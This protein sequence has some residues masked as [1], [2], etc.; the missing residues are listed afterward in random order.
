MSSFAYLKH[1][2]VD[3]LKIDG[4]FVKDITTDTVDAAMVDA[5]N[6]IGHVMGLKTIAEFAE[7]QAI[8]DLLTA[9]G[10]DYAQG[11]GIGH[12]EPLPLNTDEQH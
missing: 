4:C 9:M 3:F 12:P 2:P 8:V 11:Y 6:Q 1:L 10:V 5:I 7:D